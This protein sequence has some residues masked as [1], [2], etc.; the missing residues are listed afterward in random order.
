[1]TEDA[2]DTALILELVHIASV[3]QPIVENSDHILLTANRLLRPR[4]S[5]C[6]RRT[7]APEAR[8]WLG[9]PGPAEIH[10]AYGAAPMRR[11]YATAAGSRDASRSSIEVAHTCSASATLN[12][13]ERAA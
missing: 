3:R 6:C 9:G 4:H 11:R 12:V 2:E 5:A 13:C 8:D 10:R 7:A 1:M